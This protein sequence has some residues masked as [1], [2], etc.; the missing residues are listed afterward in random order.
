M[1]SHITQRRFALVLL[2]L[3]LFMIISGS[4]SEDVQSQIGRFAAQDPG[5]R[6]GSAGAGGVLSG[7][8]DLEQKMFG[9]AREDF[10]EVQSVQGRFPTQ[11]LVSGRA[12]T[13]TVAPAV[14]R[15][16]I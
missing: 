8:T 5:V 16:R 2:A 12:S 1:M 10:E 14:T 6:K 9:I 15:I 3:V 7:L 4:F 11:N 13:W